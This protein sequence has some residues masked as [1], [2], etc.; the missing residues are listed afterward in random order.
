M[1]D[2]TLLARKCIQLTESISSVSDEFGITAHTSRSIL[3]HNERDEKF[4]PNVGRNISKEEDV[5]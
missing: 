1:S 2:L 4:K 3:P 5:L